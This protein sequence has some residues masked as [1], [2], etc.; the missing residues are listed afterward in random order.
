[1]YVNY[2][3]IHSDAI[4]QIVVFLTARICEY[5]HNYLHCTSIIDLTQ[6]G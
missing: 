5:T 3:I 2:C 6:R 4:R 1:M